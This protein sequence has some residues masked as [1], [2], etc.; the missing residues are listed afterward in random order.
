[1]TS[2]GLVAERE[3]LPETRRT[4]SGRLAFDLPAGGRRFLQGAQGYEA[5]IVSGRVVYRNGEATGDLPGRL[6]RGRVPVTVQ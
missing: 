5:T 6:V 4:A 1:M 2:P 3:P